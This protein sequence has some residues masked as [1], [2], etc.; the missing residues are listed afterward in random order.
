M[1]TRPGKLPQVPALE[2]PCAEVVPNAS[3]SATQRE[4]GAH[5]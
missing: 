4:T 5:W 1:K 2:K 3:G